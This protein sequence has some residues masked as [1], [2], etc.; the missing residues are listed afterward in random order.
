MKKNTLPSLFLAINCL[1]ALGFASLVSAQTEKIVNGGFETGN[2]SGWT[3]VNSPG[4]ADASITASIESA[5]P[6]SGSHSVRLA[7]KGPA[8]DNANWRLRFEQL[9]QAQE[10]RL[11]QPRFLV[12]ASEEITFLVQVMQDVSPFRNFSRTY[13]IP[14]DTP[15][16]LRFSGTPNWSGTTRMSFVFGGTNTNGETV[17]VWLDDISVIE[18]SA[19]ADTASIT[20]DFDAPEP[21]ADL[22]GLLSGMGNWYGTDSTQPGQQFIDPLRLKHWRVHQSPD[23]EFI[24][25]AIASG[26]VPIVI[27]S[28]EW[29]AFDEPGNPNTPWA[30]G[31]EA[32]DAE[33]DALA[34]RYGTD[35]IYEIW[36]EPDLPESFA[37]YEG[38]TFE[39]YLEMFERMHNR[40][41]AIVPDAEII[42]P[43]LS[44]H[45]YDGF[46]WALLQQFMDFC[47]AEGLTVQ[48]LSLHLWDAD[49]NIERMRDDLLRV[50]EQFIDNPSYAAVGVE[51]LYVTEY[52]YDEMRMRPGS[53]L[54]MVRLMEEGLVDGATTS[55]WTHLR[56]CTEQSSCFDGTLAGML[57]CGGTAPRPLWWAKKW[58]A[59]SVGGR[60]EATSDNGTIVP[61]ASNHSGRGQVILASR[62]YLGPATAIDMAAVTV[63]L[64]NLDDAGIVAPGA[65]QV[66]VYVYRAPYDDMDSAHAALMEPELISQ[67]TLNVTD[68]SATLV[69]G[70]MGA[71]DAILIVF[72]E[73]DPVDFRGPAPLGTWSGKGIDDNLN[74]PAN[75]GGDAVPAPGETATWA[76]Y[77]TGNLDL[78]FNANV[79]G[80]A[81]WKLDMTSAQNNDVSIRN[82]NA[83]SR[84]LRLRTGGGNVQGN[85]LDIA[86][87]AGA[88]T[89]GGGDNPLQVVLGPSDATTSTAEIR[90]NSA[91]K[92][93]FAA[94]A[95]LI[96]GGTGARNLWIRGSG[97]V[98]ILGDI[99]L[100]GSGNLSMWGSGTLRLEGNNSGAS[101]FRAAGNGTVVFTR[102]AAI[103]SFTEFRIGFTGQ[104]GILRYVGSENAVLTKRVR[105]GEGNGSGSIESSGSG[106][107]S[108]SHADFIQPTPS[109]A[110]INLTLA[111]TNTGD[112]TISGRIINHSSSDA[113]RTLGII[114]E[115]TG[116]WILAGANSYGGPT[117]VNEGT[118]IINGSTAAA[119]AV[120]VGVD[121]VIGGNGTINGPITFDSGSRLALISGATLSLN[122]LSDLGNLRISSIDGLDAG[123]AAGSYTLLDGSGTKDTSRVLNLGR[124]NA[125]ILGTK[126]AW[127]EVDGTSLI[128]HVAAD[129]I[130][131][132]VDGGGATITGYD[133]PAYARLPDMLGGDPV[134]AIASGT[135]ENNGS[136]TRI[137]VPE[138]VTELGDG[139]F[140]GMTSLEWISFRGDA[141]ALGSGVFAGTSADIYYRK[142][143]SGW[144]AEAGFGGLALQRWDIAMNR[145][146]GRGIN[147]G[148]SFDAPCETCWGNPWQPE[149]FETIGAEAF[150]HIRLPVRWEPSDR[151][152]NEAPFTIF[153]VFFERIKEVVD[154]ALAEGLPVVLNMHH[155]DELFADA[156]GQTDRFVA[157]WQ[158]IAEFFKDYPE[159]QLIFELMNEP[160]GT[161]TPAVWNDLVSQ[162]LAAVRASNPDRL[163]AIG[164][165]FQG[166]IRG[167][168]PLVLPEDD[169]LTL[170]VHYYDPFTFTH[171]GAIWVGNSSNWVGTEW[172]DSDLERQAVRND[173]DKISNFASAHDMPVYLG[174]FG[175]IDE[176]DL[177]SRVRY[178]RFLTREFEARGWSWA[179]WQF[180]ANFAV[181]DKVTAEWNTPLVDAL[182]REPLPEANV[183][184]LSSVYTSN[185][186]SGV[187]SWTSNVHEGAAANLSGGSGSLTLDITN[188]GSAI[189]HVQ[190]RRSGIN[191][192]QGRTYR[193]TLTGSSVQG[194]TASTS[195]G[196]SATFNPYSAVAMLDFPPEGTT[197]TLY[198]QMNN[199]SDSNARINLDIG[200]AAGT[201]VLSEVRIEKYDVLFRP[202]IT[203]QPTASTLSEGQTLGDASLTGGAADVDGFFAFS[204]PS[205]V[206]PLGTSQQQ[207]TFT[208]TNTSTHTTTTFFIEVTVESVFANWID[209]FFPGETDP[210]IVG[211][212]ADP[213]GDGWN[214]EQEWLVGTDPSDPNSRF[215]AVQ[216]MVEIDGSPHFQ[217]QFDTLPGRI[218]QVQRS[219]TLASDS[220]VNVGDPIDGDGASHSV[221][222][223]MADD[224]AFFRVQ[225]EWAD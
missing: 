153:P 36:N 75:W 135:F 151:S 29:W 76:G 8:Q 101:I 196:S 19:P 54:A 59:D 57:T 179:V 44:G 213:D 108:F 193:V 68:G 102:A 7:V 221:S 52:A 103:N 47:L 165:A 190:L 97:D 27:R 140:A 11:Y 146:L 17:N 206:P 222:A 107:L 69:L 194:L 149:Y 106:T 195:V 115:G 110:N 118:L 125:A 58:Y 203:T 45:T 157:Q 219:S 211:P 50:R 31:W 180:T 164:T 147:F 86:S 114:K 120:T 22:T 161:V 51:K 28:L 202:V 156:A 18:R 150:D 175:V 123:T 144:N 189:W 26:A 199:A 215:T 170:T 63:N 79:G 35:I 223:P 82:T 113:T 174:E 61:I 4:S 116:R 139:A 32:L 209:S 56:D 80:A 128:L 104:S 134:T 184:Q 200:L 98:D 83:A 138:T 112:N 133:G 9:F 132:T 152:M 71:Y 64:E 224:K 14:A 3:L 99:T 191:L 42:G 126:A 5:N 13:T 66:P 130:T 60:V 141:P 96:R 117:L 67:Q 169:A 12:K 131:Y 121:A 143:T 173:L 176:G 201:L 137:I 15:M 49:E 177:A 197:H 205:I 81:G 16:V 127:F 48:G 21:A 192:Q 172:R 10:G 37:N 74:T 78:V 204:D 136:V 43:S 145:V 217:I 119:S 182:L 155:H 220:W 73:P 94:N 93:T 109:N 1:F 187:D 89:I 129:A 167:I 148:N 186:A 207:V 88:V 84:N 91:N 163:V 122:G 24:D 154:K 77:Q 62:D 85:S 162:G 124:A 188:G 38:G 218:Y 92:L 185:W 72:E 95:N 178:L 33:F 34:R 142:S 53:N 181:Y 166:G 39:K 30:D 105:V 46:D 100:T 40:I 41:R 87:G 216:E 23:F 25:R 70:G 212:E 214:N 168:A 90:N 171:Q 159:D 65:T 2:T 183:A 225:V 6:L 158:Q 160:H 111:G 210:A 20:V 198:F 208:P 55:C